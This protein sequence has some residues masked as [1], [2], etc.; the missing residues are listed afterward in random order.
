MAFEGPVW[1]D[2]LFLPALLIVVLRDIV[3]GRNWRN[4]TIPVVLAM[5]TALNVLYHLD[6]DL[7]GPADALRA[8]AYAI[9]AMI[10]LIGGRVMAPFTG[11]ALGVK[12]T[13]T[14]FAGALETA[15]I[16]AVLATAIL[17]AAAPDSAVLG[18]AALCAGVVLGLRMIGWR[19]LATW[20]LPIV[21]VLHVGYVWLPIGYVMTGMALIWGWVEPSAALH[22]LTAGAIGV[23]I[24]AMATRASLGHGGRALHA[25]AATVAAYVCV[26]VAALLR[27][28]TPADWAEAAAVAWIVGYG[29]FVFAYWSVLTRPRVDG[30]PG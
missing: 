3:A 23:M 26:I 19:S 1:L 6:G 10:A 13:E 16:I 9:T 4:L 11:N 21:W 22:A 28:F 29:L 2:L 7:V 8:A 20:R 18:M 30:K 24:L 27:V 17:A 5:L 15:S 12:I 25:N 14:R